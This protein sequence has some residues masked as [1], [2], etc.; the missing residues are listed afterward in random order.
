MNGTLSAAARRLER[1]RSCLEDHKLAG[2]LVTHLPNLR[3]LTGFSGSNGWLLIGPSQT[4]FATDGRYEEQA[5]EEIPSDL[6]LEIMVPKDGILPELAARAGA[7]FGDAAVGFDGR[8]VS[9][10][11]CERL[12]DNGAPVEWSAVSGIVERFR[13]VK[14]EDEIAA[15]QRAADIAVAALRETLP[16][17]EPGLRELDIACELDYRMRRLGAE[18][19]AFE[20]IVAS[21]PRTSL[22]H[23][24]TGERRIEVGDLLLCDFGAR[25]RGYCADITRTFVVGPP[26]PRQREVYQAVLEAQHKACQALRHGVPAVEVDAAAR[27][28]FEAREMEDAFLHSTGHGLGL[29]VHEAPRLFRKAEERLEARMVVT[30]EPGLYFPGW[31]GVRIEDDM[32]VTEGQPRSL[33]DFEKDDLK[34]LPA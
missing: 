11:D 33:V 26:Q 25:W 15:I 18:G 5:E 13:A 21:G 19:P 24:A 14:D 34:S 8:H 29:E 20:T 22:P 10:T 3:Y 12:R 2:F 32:V 9:Y 1:V 17:V 4:I 16:I 28:V 7:E 6:G 30:V 23:A 31:G 27:S